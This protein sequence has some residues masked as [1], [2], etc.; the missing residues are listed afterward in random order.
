[1]NEMS[2]VESYTKAILEMFSDRSFGLV[3]IERV[4]GGRFAIAFQ[5]ESS[6]F[7][8]SI[9]V[10]DLSLFQVEFLT[11]ILIDE[12]RTPGAAL[13]ALLLFNA[14]Y[15][16]S[17][18]VSY[19]LVDEGESMDSATRE[20]SL[21]DIRDGTGLPTALANLR[22]MYGIEL[23]DKTSEQDWCLAFDAA[24][25]TLINHLNAVMQ[26]FDLIGIEYQVATFPSP[27]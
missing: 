6:I 5:Y 2:I 4:G 3:D 26:N 13:K 1:M 14:M 18:L 16:T 23:F 10:A 20:I 19:A 24:V 8:L 9:E 25:G 7:R 21:L 15:H 22:L 17:P 27:E 11:P 12:R